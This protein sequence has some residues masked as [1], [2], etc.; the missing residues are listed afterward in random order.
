MRLRIGRRTFAP[1]IAALLLT[2]AGVALFGSLGRWQLQRAAEQ[3]ALE[4]QFERGTGP[5]HALSSA[6]D[7]VP[8]YQR[9][10]VTGHSDPTRQNLRDNITSRST[11]RYYVLTP[12]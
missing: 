1:G 5:A 9:V 8:R 7:R 11:T 2:A 4:M 10:E 6:L 3:R 12:P